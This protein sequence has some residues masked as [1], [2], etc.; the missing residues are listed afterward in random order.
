MVSLPNTRTPVGRTR[1]TT[2]SRSFAP[3]SMPTPEPNWSSLRMSF[4]MASS[5]G[6]RIQLLQ[7]ESYQ[8][9]MWMGGRSGGMY[10]TWAATVRREVG[11]PAVRRAAGGG[12]ADGENRVALQT[13][14]VRRGPDRFQEEQEAARAERRGGSPRDKSRDG[15]AF[16][17][18]A[19]R[20]A[21]WRCSTS[22][23]SR[24]RRRKGS[25]PG[26]APEPAA[27]PSAPL[28]ARHVGS[29]K[30]VRRYAFHKQ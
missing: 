19:A 15:L 20:T 22:T 17:P 2:T 24:G 5:S 13:Q 23:R 12:G 6:M 11:N 30:N 18:M 14:A 7:A 27:A 4:G 8:R 25:P 29:V 21:G 3:I 16:R 28:R 9:R 26:R 10:F 1:A